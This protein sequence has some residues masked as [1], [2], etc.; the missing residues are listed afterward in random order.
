M[1][2]FC[3]LLA[4][5]VMRLWEDTSA[6]LR[7]QTPPRHEYRMAKLAAR[8]ANGGRVPTSA[9][10]RYLA[11]LLDDAWDSA[12]HRRELMAD[13]RAEKRTRKAAAKIDRDRARWAAQDGDP[14]ANVDPAAPTGPDK[15]GFDAQAPQAADPANPAG[16][17]NPAAPGAPAPGTARP[18]APTAPPAGVSPG[19]PA[20]P[21]APPAANTAP[22]SPHGTAPALNPRGHVGF[23]ALAPRTVNLD[24]LQLG[25]DTGHYGRVGLATESLA[26][27]LLQ[28]AAEVNTQGLDDE[29]VYPL[30]AQQQATVDR[31]RENVDDPGRHRIPVADFQALPVSVRA[32]LL[33]A[34]AQEP[35]A[36]VT[37]VPGAEDVEALALLNARYNGEF[38]PST[39]YVHPDD[40][41][42]DVR[43]RVAAD[44]ASMAAEQAAQSAAQAAAQTQQ[45]TPPVAPQANSSSGPDEE[46]RAFEEQPERQE[47]RDQLQRGYS[48]ARQEGRGLQPAAPLPPGM[49]WL[50]PSA[51]P[52]PVP[53]PVDTE[54]AAPDHPITKEDS[55]PAPIN[56][57]P[58]NVIPF[59]RN[60]NAK[61]VPTRME[62]PVT[63]PTPTSTGGTEVTGLGSAITYT[64][65]LAGW[66]THTHDQVSAIVPSAEEASSS[67][68]QA[69]EGLAAGGVTGPALADIATVQEQV[70]SAAQAVRTALSNFEAASA[71]ATNLRATLVRHQ[72]TVGEAYQ[73][74][75]D[76]GTREFVT[77]E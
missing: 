59:Q 72:Q 44:M 51:P 67:C 52:A 50:H 8:E 4:Y 70:V 34:M 75:P 43:A 19:T 2:L 18:A 15:V 48:Q 1:F 31:W 56:E 27:D 9:A 14:T 69:R 32:D 33:D 77:A 40:A 47:L 66:C 12:H 63:T 54:L 45:T 28:R 11:G 61:F 37:V 13:H 62:L 46:L 7:G 68:E 71:A 36:G 22:T 65:N 73:N 21:A 6:R 60:N 49:D 35:G 24:P 58:D 53:Q 26:E 74:N 29:A 42:P 17:S 16:P 64:G 5:F 39:L 41:P 23:G 3:L 10:G 55:T 20:A 30:T 76:A 38:D 25:A 57:L